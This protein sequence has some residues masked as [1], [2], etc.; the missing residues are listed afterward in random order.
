MHCAFQGYTTRLEFP[1]ALKYVDV[2]AA[3]PDH[4]RAG[5]LRVLKINRK[6]I[7]GEF[8]M[9]M[10]SDSQELSEF[11]TTLV[12]RMNTQSPGSS[13]TNTRKGTA[14]MRTRA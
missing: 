12:D 4:G 7:E 6:P 9:V 13:N 14:S 11:A 8:L 5:S 2:Y 10:G 3:H 1:R